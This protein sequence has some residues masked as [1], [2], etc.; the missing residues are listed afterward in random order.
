M[1]EDDAQGLL[2]TGR[3]MMLIALAG[4]LIVGFFG[5]SIGS[6]AAAIAVLTVLISIFGAVKISTGLKQST[7]SKIIYAVCMLI[8]LI[9]FILIITLTVRAHKALD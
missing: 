7:L 9:G 6:L 8:P 2:K 5:K 1:Q 3:M 4:Y